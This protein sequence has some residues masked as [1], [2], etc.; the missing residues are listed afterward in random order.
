MTENLDHANKK[1]WFEETS[2]HTTDLL[3]SL[4]DLDT[5]PSLEDKSLKS[6]Q[7]V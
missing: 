1:Y 3:S 6:I 7:M 5:E 2:V 4:L